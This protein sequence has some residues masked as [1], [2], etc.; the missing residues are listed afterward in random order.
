MYNIQN[1]GG[2]TYISNFYVD[3]VDD[4]EALY[5][6]LDAHLDQKIQANNKKM[7]RDIRSLR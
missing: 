4:I 2:N 3:G 7:A 6:K 1:M 5:K